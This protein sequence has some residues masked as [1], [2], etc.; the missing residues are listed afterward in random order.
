MLWYG[1]TAILFFK[2]H[3]KFYNRNIF[4]IANIRTYLTQISNIQISWRSKIGIQSCPMHVCE[5]KQQSLRTS[6]LRQS[7]TKKPCFWFVSYFVSNQ[8]KIILGIFGNDEIRNHLW[9]AMQEG[10]PA[11]PASVRVQ[12]LAPR[13]CLLSKLVRDSPTKYARSQSPACDTAS[14]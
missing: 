10:A 6:V 9:A 14:T 11:H 13:P 8:V 4:F 7:K 2:F 12:A 3:F 1:H 5:I